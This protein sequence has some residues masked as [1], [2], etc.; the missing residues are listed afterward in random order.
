MFRIYD[1]DTK[2]TTLKGQDLIGEVECSL[3]EIMT[4]QGTEIVKTLPKKAGS[5]CIT[6]QEI[7]GCKEVATILF[8]GEKLDKKDTFGKS[9][10][11]LVLSRHNKND[12]YSPV[13]NTGFQKDTLNPKWQPLSIPVRTLCRGDYNANFRIE[14]FDWDKNE[15]HD[16]I[17]ECYTNLNQL[18]DGKPLP[19]INPKKTSKKGYQNSG[20]LH[21]QIESITLDKSFLDYLREGIQLHF[22]VAVDFTASNGN[23]KE[24]SSLH[25]LEEGKDNP[26][27]TA[28]KSIG[29]IIQDYRKGQYFYIY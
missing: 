28:I 17:G 16:L 26:Y 25:Y 23:P 12:T 24:N 18:K 7:S 11:F 20:L 10:P 2:T 29:E 13:F 19:L 4:F 14:C 15:K 6:G 1:W 3:A 8:S 22:T 27:T 9:D 5:L 21:A